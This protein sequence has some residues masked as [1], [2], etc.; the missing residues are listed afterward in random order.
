MSC[1]LC[2]HASVRD[3]RTHVIQYNGKDGKVRQILEGGRIRIA[4]DDGSD[5]GVKLQNLQIL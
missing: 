1:H 2:A 3:T 4:L 5:L